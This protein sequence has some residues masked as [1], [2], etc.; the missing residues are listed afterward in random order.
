MSTFIKG[1]IVDF[2]DGIIVHQTNCC[3]AIEADVSVS[4]INAWPQVKDRYLELCNSKKPKELL[5]GI[6]VV[7][8][9]DNLK[10]VNCFSQ[11]DSGD[12]IKTNEKYT[13][14]GLLIRNINYICNENP[15]T[16]VYIP[17]GIGCKIAGGDWN[18]IYAGIKN[19]NNLIIVE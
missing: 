1:N 9:S 12:S 2:E 5:G 11:L 4:I 16:K 15:E 6:Q 14:E 7:P 17:F 13:D 18:V 3:G 10:I 19:N 8:I